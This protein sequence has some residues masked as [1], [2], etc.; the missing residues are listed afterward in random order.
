MFHLAWR[1]KGHVPAEAASCALAGGVRELDFLDD[2]FLG[3]NLFLGWNFR[4]GWV[5]D[6]LERKEDAHGV[7]IWLKLVSFLTKC[8][9]HPSSD[10]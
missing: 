3:E 8:E 7:E 9:S 10:G 6:L 4:S 5:G 2:L 1:Y